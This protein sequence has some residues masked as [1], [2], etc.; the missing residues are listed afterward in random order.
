MWSANGVTQLVTA[1]FLLVETELLYLLTVSRESGSPSDQGRWLRLRLRLDMIG[2]RLGSAVLLVAQLMLSGISCS[3]CGSADSGWDQ[4]FFERHSW[5]W[6]GSAV[7]FVVQ[8]MLS[9]TNILFAVKQLMKILEGCWSADYVS[10]N[11]W[12][13]AAVLLNVSSW[14]NFFFAVSR[15]SLITELNQQFPNCSW[16]LQFPDCC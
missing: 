7:L 13:G 15:L 16:N 5:F 14:L 4:L 8:L 6:V 11:S 1:G 10:A 9:W 12:Q 3:S 2:E